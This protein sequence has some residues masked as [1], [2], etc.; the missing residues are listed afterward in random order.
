MV[1]RPTWLSDRKDGECGHMVTM[2]IVTLM[3]MAGGSVSEIC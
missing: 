2:V 1:M 3:T